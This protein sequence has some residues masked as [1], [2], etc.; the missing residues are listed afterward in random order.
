MTKTLSVSAIQNGTVIDHIPP[1]QAT[2]IIQ[3]LSLLADQPHPIMIGM[4]LHSARI[5]KKDLVK[6]ENC[7]LPPE[8]INKI[9]A[10]APSATINM[11]EN[12][13]VVRKISACL[14]PAIHSVFVCQNT[15]C[16]T[17]HE[18]VDTI[19]HLTQEAAHI[20]LTCHYC[21]KTFDRDSIGVRV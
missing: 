10:F 14:T 11:I 20:F 13:Q 6:M 21:R 17:R 7:L 12:Y 15:A 1:G 19:F 5:G 4:N 9:V 3:L 2:R 8:E 16:I 18:Q